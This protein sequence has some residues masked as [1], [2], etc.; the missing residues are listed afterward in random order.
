[1]VLLGGYSKRKDRKCSFLPAFWS[2]SDEL[3]PAKAVTD[4]GVDD[5]T[6][7]EVTESS[8]FDRSM[9]TTSETI[10]FLEV[11]MSVY[12]RI[13]HMSDF[14]S[15]KAK[16]YLIAHSCATLPTSTPNK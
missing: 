15:A 16:Y 8:S 6:A 13:S 12:Y 11:L 10:C 5:E 3:I 2:F 9:S 14:S 1:M 7:K 4:E